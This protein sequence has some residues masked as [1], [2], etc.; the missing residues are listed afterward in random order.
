MMENTLFF[1]Y[2]PKAIC[3]SPKFWYPCLHPRSIFFLEGLFVGTSMLGLQG[4]FPT[5]QLSRIVPSWDP[6]YHL[7][8]PSPLPPIHTHAVSSTAS[9]LLSRDG[10]AAQQTPTGLSTQVIKRP[11]GEVYSLDSASGLTLRR[12]YMLT[13]IKIQNPGPKSEL[14]TFQR[15][16]LIFCLKPVKCNELKE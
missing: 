4:A 8:P 10:E 7:V 3:S 15:R 11:W 5:L 9:Q 6:R 12:S 1:L 14:H 13:L 16:H 2:L